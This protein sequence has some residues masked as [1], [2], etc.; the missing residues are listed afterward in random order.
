MADLADDLLEG[1]QCLLLGAPPPGLRHALSDV[2]ATRQAPLATVYD[3]SALAP[4]DILRRAAAAGMNYSAAVP[5]GIWWI[6]DVPVS[7]TSAWTAEAIRLADA[8]RN[9]APAR[10][11]LLVLPMPDDV[12]APPGLAVAAYRAN[13]LGRLDL[14]VAARYSAAAGAGNGL[15]GRLR[16][17][18]AV[19]MAASLL[20]R[21]AALDAL[22]HWMRAPD[23]A[24]CDPDCFADHAA[25]G[26]MP[27]ALPAYALW[28]AQH[29]ALLGEIEA[30]RLAA[31]RASPCWRVPYSEPAAEGRPERRIERAEMLEL[32]H[33]CA[34]LRD[35]REPPDSPL[36][37][38][39]RTLRDMRNAL[40][41]FQP[42]TLAELRAAEQGVATC[43]GFRQRQARRLE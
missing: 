2:L 30:L 5:A 31:V 6:E 22:G 13:P 24:L 16:L 41:H 19:Q 38:H 29:E 32:R 17:T 8:G 37:R 36:Y 27:T 33:L 34:Q 11:T 21:A 42:V 9:E 26:N 1:R 7:R 43:A 39:L 40:S 15:L 3:D 10:R 23:A 35:A 4:D 14:E 25:A 20:P 12:I 18:L 28:R